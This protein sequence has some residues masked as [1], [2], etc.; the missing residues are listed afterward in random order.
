[1]SRLVNYVRE[2]TIMAVNNRR[3]KVTELYFDN[4]ESNLKNFVKQKNQYK[5]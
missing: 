5:D 4:I 1:M 2:S 3:L